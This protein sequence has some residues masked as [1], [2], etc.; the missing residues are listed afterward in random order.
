MRRISIL[1]CI[2]SIG[3][4]A[5]SEN[6]LAEII[7]RID[8]REFDV[9]LCCFEDSPRMR[10]LTA[11]CTPLL[12]PG[13]KIASIDGIR[14]IRRLRG[15]IK[16]QRI[17]IVHTWMVDANIVG[18]LASLGPGSPLVV[19]GRR[20]L[21]YWFTPRH[22]ALYRFLNRFTTRILANSDGVKSAVMERE[23]VSGHRIDVLHNGVDTEL[24]APGCGNRGVP[25]SL[26]VPADA[27][28]VGIV[29]NLRPVKDIG[30]FLRAAKQVLK[31]VPKAA[32]VIV[33]TGPLRD[34]LG[35]LAKTLGIASSVY[36]S[37]GKGDVLDH[38][39]RMDVACLTSRSEGFSNA[40]LESMAVGIPVVATHTGGNPEAVDHGVSGY[41]FP[42][43]DVE[44]LAGHLI[45]LLTH[46][47]T[48]IR[49]GKLARVHCE[50]MFAMGR[51]VDRYAAYYR[52][53]VMGTKEDLLTGSEL[54]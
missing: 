39:G 54:A 52:R 35:N 36:F 37:D 45:H 20:N 42:V 50:T 32:F 6:Q 17:D 49:M 12:L 31:E 13:G 4:Q 8:K 27:P 5:G 47:E 10:E 21:G 14:R 30:V 2:D 41:L 15:Y 48:R 34:E 22:L 11:H 33:G 44:Q 19:S 7:R 26:G 16:N 23:G 1:Y 51:A 43:G 46:E 9:H 29:A 38:L 24:Y 53:L 3:A 40:L 18:I 28:V 25:A